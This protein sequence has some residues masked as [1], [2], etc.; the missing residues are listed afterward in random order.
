MFVFHSPG[1]DEKQ[2]PNFFHRYRLD[3]AFNPVY[4]PV[5]SQCPVRSSKE[6]SV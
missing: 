4:A 5:P 1:P 3:A 6:L 2:R